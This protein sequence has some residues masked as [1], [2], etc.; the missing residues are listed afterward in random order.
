M[1][2][3]KKAL[4]CR[5]V[6]LNKVYD[7]FSFQRYLEEKELFQPCNLLESH[8]NAQRKSSA[9]RERH[10]QRKF[11]KANTALCKLNFLL[12][13]K[14]KTNLVTLRKYNS[15][16]QYIIKLICE[17]SCARREFARQGG[18]FFKSYSAVQKFPLIKGNHECLFINKTFLRIQ[19]KL[20]F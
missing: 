4:K 12:H 20:Q 1:S 14:P 2:D 16:L 13:L 7:C 18:R 8:S 19:K 11:F 3:T 10:G 5:I 9:K 15:H 6:C 17:A